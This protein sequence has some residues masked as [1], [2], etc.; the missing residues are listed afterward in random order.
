V[1]ALILDVLVTARLATALGVASDLYP[2]WLGARAWLLEGI[3]PYAPEIGDRI[4]ADMVAGLGWDGQTDSGAF[5]FGFVYPGYVAILLAPIAV[6]PFPIAAT[7]WLLLAQGAIVG[8]TILLWRTTPSAHNH[9]RIPEVVAVALAV[10]W[11]PAAFNLVFGQFATLVTLLLALAVTLARRGHSIASGV[12]LA[13]AMVKPQLGLAPAIASGI[14][15]VYGAWRRAGSGRHAGASLTMIAILVGGSLVI[16]P[17]WVAPFFDGVADY[18]RAAKAT[19]PAILIADAVT[20]VTTERWPTRDLPGTFEP[21][22]LGIGVAV[23]ALIFVGWHRQAVRDPGVP[24]AITAGALAAAWLMPPTYEWNHVTCLLVLVP[25]VRRGGRAHAVAWL[26]ASIATL[27][28][29]LAWPD[30]SRATWPVI[31][32][33]VWLHDAATA[34]R[35]RSSDPFNSSAP[36]TPR[37]RDDDPLDVPVAHA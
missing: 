19:S 5:A 2:R 11:P 10:V 21:L 8:A 18:A 36:S 31:L 1:C 12:T 6:V 35:L 14:A 13:L 16:L 4:R 22:P 7:V 3:N 9:A 26:G 32:L 15:D 29:V 33:A 20:R 23:V 25:W 17:G 27:P 30:G 24:S 28:L 34:C 37:P